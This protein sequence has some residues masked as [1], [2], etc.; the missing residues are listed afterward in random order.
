M[1]D[2]L[3]TDPEFISLQYQTGASEAL[4]VEAAEA[5]FAVGGGASSNTGGAS[6]GGGGGSGVI[7]GGGGG[8]TGGGGYGGGEQPPCFIGTTKILMSGN[9]GHVRQITDIKCGTDTVK[10]FDT[11]GILY[12]AL[13]TGF[14]VHAV[15]EYL[16]VEFDNGAHLFVTNE[17]PIW[18]GED[19]FTPAGELGRGDTVAALHKGGWKLIWVDS[20]KKIRFPDR[21][22]VYNLEV[23]KYRTYIAEGIG[24]HNL[25]NQLEQP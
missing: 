4:A 21:V 5:A 22:L 10:A 9:F 23:E 15:T 25:K 24:V 7:G 19:I 17:H 3:E 8:T 11:N 20:V 12:D 1:I 13:V 18:G 16:A 14:F 6:V 2:N